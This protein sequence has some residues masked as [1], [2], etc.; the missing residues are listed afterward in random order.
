MIYP[1]ETDEDALSFLIEARKNKPSDIKVLKP[2]IVLDKDGNYTR[3]V[4]EIFNFKK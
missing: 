4:R 1:K 3:E 2:V